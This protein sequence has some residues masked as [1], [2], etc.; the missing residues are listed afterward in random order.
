MKTCPT[1]QQTSVNLKSLN[2][3]TDFFTSP[4]HVYKDAIT[5]RYLGK[6]GPHNRE[7]NLCC[8]LETVCRAASLAMKERMKLW[9]DRFKQLHPRERR[10]I[11][12]SANIVE[13]KD[14]LISEENLSGLCYSAHKDVR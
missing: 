2:E 10:L 11:G 12:V 7:P 3:P 4:L 6:R 8:H 9:T 5:L 1:L 13:P 14:V